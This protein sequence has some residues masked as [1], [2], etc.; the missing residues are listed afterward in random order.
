MFFDD[1]P[2]TF[3]DH[4]QNTSSWLLDHASVHASYASPVHSYVVANVKVIVW[5]LAIA[6][7]SLSVLMGVLAFYFF[8]RMEKRYRH[9]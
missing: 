8:W 2:T 4:L 6:I 3:N 1:I 5:I 7:S 9:K